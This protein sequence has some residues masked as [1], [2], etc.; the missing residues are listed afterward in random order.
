MTNGGSIPQTPKK[1][2]KKAEPGSSAKRR[3]GNTGKALKPKA[4]NEDEDAAA[5]QEGKLG[6]DEVDEANEETA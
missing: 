5:D 1:P 6:E 3:K 4:E 2:R